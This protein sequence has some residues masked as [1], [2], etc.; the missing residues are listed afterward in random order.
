MSKTNE[1]KTY[2][3]V[4]P[5]LS[6]YPIDRAEGK[7]EIIKARTI[8][9][10]DDHYWLAVVKVKS[11][12]GQNGPRESIRGYRWQ[13]KKPYSR[14]GEPEKP[15]RWMVDLKMNFNKKSQWVD[16]KNAVDEMFKDMPD[17]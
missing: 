11:A 9:K 6:D 12:F 13:W 15:E 7:M 14:A 17:E 2:E 8:Y 10:W 4:Q 3:V 1:K 16:F 5:Q